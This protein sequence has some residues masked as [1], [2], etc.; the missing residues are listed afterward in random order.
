MSVWEIILIAVG[1][2]ADAFAI[3]VSLGL[4]SHDAGGK[5][6]TLKHAL[7]AGA[8]FGGSQAV[9]PFLGWLLGSL[10]A[11]YVRR[12]APFIACAFLAL[13]GGKM[14]FDAVRDIQKSKK[15]ESDENSHIK[16]TNP[17]GALNMF[18]LAV[19]DSVDA[20][21]MG[22]SYAALEVGIISACLITGAV[23]FIISAAGVKIGAV[24]GAKYESKAEIA[25]GVILLLLAIKQLIP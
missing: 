12:Y 21:A 9:M 8:W 24:F 10:F 18:I 19:A 23:T 5:H 16:K 13:I 20:F 6:A 1:L 7:L 14:I 11:K 2:S 17:W 3:S 15:G 25:G 4:S 22:V